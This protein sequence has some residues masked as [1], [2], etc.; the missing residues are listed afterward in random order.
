MPLY[1]YVC[2]DCGF[3]KEHFDA[4]AKD[5]VRTCPKCES[6]D[7]NKKLSMFALNVEYSNVHDINENKIDPAVKQTYEKIGREALDHDSKT[8]DNLFGKEKV[9]NTYYTSDD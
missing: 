5:I 3:S 1:D 6:T 9:E 7:Y 4:P 8:L 2:N